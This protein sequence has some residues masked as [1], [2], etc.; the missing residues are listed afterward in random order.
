MAIPNSAASIMGR[1]SSDPQTMSG[2]VSN[3]GTSKSR[4]SKGITKSRVTRGWFTNAEMT[5]QATSC[6]RENHCESGT[7]IATLSSTQPGIQ[8][9]PSRIRASSL[10]SCGR[11]IASVHSLETL[12]GV[13]PAPASTQ[14]SS[15]RASTSAGSVIS[16]VVVAATMFMNWQWLTNCLKMM[17]YTPLGLLGSD[18]STVAA[19]PAQ[20]PKTIRKLRRVRTIIPAAS[21]HREQ[22]RSGSVP[23]AKPGRQAPQR[24]PSATDSPPSS[25]HKFPPVQVLPSP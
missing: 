21:G 22:G 8:T 2:C 23:C 11:S 16:V 25:R 13:V 6:W 15:S 4:H 19:S 3:R 18:T 7:N 24:G 17:P 10:D 9:Q 20:R 5:Q 12:R 1:C 14:E